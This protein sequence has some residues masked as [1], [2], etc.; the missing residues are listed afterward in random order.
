M[1]CCCTRVLNLCN[2]NVCGDVEFEA[3]AEI[4]GV[5]KM[6]VQFLNM[7][8]AIEVEFAQD[9]IL[10]FPLGELNENYEYTVEL[11]DPNGDK[12]TI[13]KDAVEYDCFKFRTI[14]QKTLVAV[15]VES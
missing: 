4:P 12:V 15:E 8:F 10:I 1:P 2:Q 14:I 13:T 6:V 7:S 9:E 3:T 5:Y 11:F